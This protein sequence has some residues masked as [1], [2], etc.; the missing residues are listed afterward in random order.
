MGVGSGAK[1]RKG[2]EE[3]I[4]KEGLDCE[5]TFAV[6]HK[7]PLLY[8]MALLREAQQSTKSELITH[9]ISH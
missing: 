9:D 1:R 2:W 7:F 5:L 8:I 4:N 6:V 3:G